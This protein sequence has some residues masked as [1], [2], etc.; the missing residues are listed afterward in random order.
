[1]PRPALPDHFAGQDVESG[2]E[3]GGAVTL[4]VVGHRSRPATLERRGGLGPVQR[5]DLT[6][7]VGT[8][9]DSLVRGIDVKPD[10]IDELVLEAF[11]VRQL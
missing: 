11:I 8:E 3:G 1:M 6:L 4:V 7:L 10:H 9:D 2:E 5:L